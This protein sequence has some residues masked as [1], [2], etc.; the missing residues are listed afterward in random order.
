[1]NWGRY[2]LFA[3]G[4]IDAMAMDVQS[5]VIPRTDVVFLAL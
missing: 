5:D 4:T 3:L 1:M 2:V